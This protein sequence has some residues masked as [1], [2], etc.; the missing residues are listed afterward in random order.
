M[1]TFTVRP[2]GCS[3]PE[4]SVHV[5]YDGFAEGKIVFNMLVLYGLVFFVLYLITF[6]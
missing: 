5:N 1:W 2:L 4:R 3:L 6:S